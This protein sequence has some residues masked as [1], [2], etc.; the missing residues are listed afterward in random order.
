VAEAGITVISSDLSESGIAQSQRRGIE[1]FRLSAI[2]DPLAAPF[3][4]QAFDAIVCIEVIEHLYS[5]A[6]VAAVAMQALPPRG[7]S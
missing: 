6:T 3:G 7:L 4:R 5:P 1:K 2:Y